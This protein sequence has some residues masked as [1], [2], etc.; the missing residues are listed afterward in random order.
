MKNVRV[1]AVGGG[2]RVAT[3]NLFGKLRVE[4]VLQC[5]FGGLAERGRRLVG[6]KN[7]SSRDPSERIADPA[8]YFSRGNI[9]IFRWCKV[10]N[11]NIR[12]FRWSTPFS[13]NAHSSFKRDKSP[14]G[15]RRPG[16]NMP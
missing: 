11:N 6:K 5:F 14:S 12:I 1:C 13:I 15:L 16:Y 10:R 7:G 8:S 3:A 4:N 2:A 9:R